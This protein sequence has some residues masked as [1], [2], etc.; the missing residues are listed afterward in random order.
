MAEEPRDG[1]IK[2]GKPQNAFTTLMNSSQRNPSPLIEPKPSVF[3][4][5]LGRN[6]LGAYLE[7]PQTFSPLTVKYYDDNFVVITDLYPKS[8]LHLLLLPR[9]P[10][11]YYK[12]PFDAFSCN[13]AESS[14]FLSKVQH[15]TR[16][17]CKLAASELRRMYARYSQTEQI[18]TKALE[19]DQP[20]EGDL[21][22]GRDWEAELRCG[23]HAHPSMNHLHIHIISVDRHSPRLTNRKHYNSFATPF[24]IDIEE[25][26]LADD[27]ERRHPGRAGYLKQDLKCWRCGINFGNKFAALKHHL[28]KEFEEW[29]CI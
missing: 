25:F 29:K 2:K 16:K 15:E 6:G 10:A 7:S 11:Q 8:S 27:D 19:S 23:I 4:P 9:D 13:D 14:A 1:E 24:F 12:H 17:V 26:P 5:L 22:P 18:R 20:P 21:P 3:K 28:E